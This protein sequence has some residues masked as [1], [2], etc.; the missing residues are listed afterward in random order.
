[1]GYPSG[2]PELAPIG[3]EILIVTLFGLLMPPL[4]YWLY[5]IEENRARRTG[6]L[7]EY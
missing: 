4:G 6:S 3:V 5:R 2:F 7:S 1:M